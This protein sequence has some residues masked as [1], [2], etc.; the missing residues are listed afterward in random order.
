MSDETEPADV[1]DAQ[2]PKAKGPYGA[3]D[4]F[5]SRRV[6]ALQSQYLKNV[7]GA[8]A[9]L[10]RLRRA[11]GDEPGA[12]PVVWQE[13]LGLPEQFV[14]RGDDP[15][16]AERAV[17]YA[18]TLYAT[19]QQSQGQSMH[20]RGYGLGRAAR[21]LGRS[22]VASEQAVLRRFQALG[23]AT[24]LAEAATHAR[25]LV[26]QFRGATIPLDYGRLSVDFVRFQDPRQIASVRL[27]WG[28]DY[29]R[30]YRDT[31]SAAKS[32]TDSSE[33]SQGENS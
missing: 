30:A 5:V 11:V 15:S 7:S 4:D 22:G 17:H 24:S 14:G 10:A 18:L 20:R 13:T 31:D 19:H 28:R 29:Y 9:S 16:R 21:L 26:T 25:G 27:T 12:N 23:T 1:P 2:E 6:G 3:L 8:T 33:P 32:D